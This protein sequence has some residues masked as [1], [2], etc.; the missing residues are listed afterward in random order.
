[1]NWRLLLAILALT[2][3]ATRDDPPPS[4]VDANAQPLIRV[5]PEGFER[6]L[7]SKRP[8]PSEDLVEV[9]VET[10]PEGF[11]T[12][13]QVLRS[14]DPCFDQSVLEAVRKWRYPPKF[15]DGELAARTGVKALLIFK[16]SGEDGASPE[17][18]P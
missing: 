11:V 10:D 9:I 6:C 4:V 3:C 13:A 14:T 17:E 16:L 15:V 5:G 18:R 7:E 8:G 2:A 1:M 12:D